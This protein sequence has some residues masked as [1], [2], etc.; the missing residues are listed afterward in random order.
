[1]YE[2]QLGNLINNQLTL[3]QMAFTK[4]N[5]QNTIEMVFECS[6]SFRHKPFN[7]K[8]HYKKKCLKISTWIKWKVK[9]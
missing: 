9:F 5:I 8:W 3:D 2:Q 1:M 6:L 7:N 4:E